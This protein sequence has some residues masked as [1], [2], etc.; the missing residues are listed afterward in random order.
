MPLHAGFATVDIT[1]EIGLWM[2]GYGGRTESESIL[3]PLELQALVVSDEATTLVLIAADLL[4]YDSEFVAAAR[5]AVAAEL[6]TLPDAVLLNGSH[7]H[8][9]PA[10][11]NH[12]VIEAPHCSAAY[13]Q[14][15]LEAVVRT[16]KQAAEAREGVTAE[17][18]WG[19]CRVG[20]NRRA[21]GPPYQMMPNPRGFYDDTVG[22]L[23]FRRLSDRGF[24]A[25]VFNASCHPTT[26]GAQTMFSADW[27]GAARRSLD[28]ALD[29][30][31][32]LFLQAACGNIR[33]R[34][35]DPAEV[36]KFRQGSPEEFQRMGQACAHEVLRILEDELQPAA[37]P[38]SFARATCE[39]P[40][41]N[42]P[43]ADELA[44][45]AAGDDK[46]RPSWAQW[47]L[48]HHPN[49]LPTQLPYEA[50]LLTI[51]D[52]VSILALPGEVV[53]E[54]GAAARATVPRPTLFAGY[55]NG[56]P[57]YVPNARIRRQ[58]GYEAGRGSNEFFGLPGW[59]R[60]DSELV[61]LAAVE[62][63]CAKGEA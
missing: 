25:V 10:F 46:Y 58:G 21:P 24:A 22:V 28:L 47:L 8:G 36:T 16:A 61:I 63:A 40:L 17:H 18:G 43:S 33:P 19:R 39:L 5:A 15:V 30:P 6:G 31:R 34:T 3:D 59:L 38:L 2:S 57:C 23:A 62:Q 53:S 32:T 9:G 20:I 37:G 48:D 29:G 14:R 45:L 13:R 54:L 49:G 26:L 50:Q 7:T 35:V 44:A 60:E 56:L 51:G 27:P 52:D 41:D 12:L 55:S 4:G 11:I 42:Q 1:P